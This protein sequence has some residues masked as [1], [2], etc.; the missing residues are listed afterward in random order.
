MAYAGVDSMGTLLFLLFYVSFGQKRFILGISAI[1]THFSVA[2]YLVF[3]IYKRSSL[4]ARL[5]VLSF[6]LPIL[7]ALAFTP[8][9]PVL[10]SF[11]SYKFYY[12]FVWGLILAALLSGPLFWLLAYPSSWILY[13]P[14]SIA[15]GMEHHVQVRY[16]LPAMAIQAT[17]QLRP[18]PKF[19][20]KHVKAPLPAQPEGDE[21]LE[22]VLA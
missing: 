14:G 15:S 12:A 13:L 22:E 18:L 16:Y 1:L 19:L 8:Y 2:P 6:L 10:W 4:A 9:S 21:T 20:R 11:L 5:T 3:S 17:T 7:I